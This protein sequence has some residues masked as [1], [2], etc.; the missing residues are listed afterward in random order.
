VSLLRVF[1][2]PHVQYCVE[3]LRAI[4]VRAICVE[5]LCRIELFAWALLRGAVICV[6]LFAWIAIWRGAI[7][8]SYLRGAICVQLFAA[9][10]VQHFFEEHL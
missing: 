2:A 3:L 9:I 7:A 1:R 4:C 6:E 8:W 10:C 5:L